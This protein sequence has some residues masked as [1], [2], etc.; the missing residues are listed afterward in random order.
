MLLQI[1]HALDFDTQLRDI[2]TEIA[3]ESGYLS[4]TGILRYIQGL[5]GC[6]IRVELS[7]KRIGL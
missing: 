3:I 7:G 2:L 4:I 1:A 6:F 5:E